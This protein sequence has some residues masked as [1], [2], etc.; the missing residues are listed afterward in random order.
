MADVPVG[1]GLVG[2]N[3]YW[4]WAFFLIAVR[5]IHLTASVGVARLDCRSLG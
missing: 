4:M 3:F 1:G 5:G 2:L